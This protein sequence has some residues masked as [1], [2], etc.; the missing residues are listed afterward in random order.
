VALR[1]IAMLIGAGVALSA[2]QG[3]L[4]MLC[5]APD[6][7]SIAAFLTVAVLGAGTIRTGLDLRRA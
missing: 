1:A 6:G 3:L 2:G 5:G 7:G 4:A